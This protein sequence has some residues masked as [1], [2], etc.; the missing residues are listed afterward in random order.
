MP[1]RDLLGWLS[2]L[3]ES[4]ARHDIR[5]ALAGGLA[6]AVRAQ[7]RATIDIDLV[8]AADPSAVAAVR[9]AASAAG[10]LQTTKRAMA[11]RRVSILRMLAPPDATG[12]PIA[13]DCLLLPAPLE[14]DVLARAT[15]VSLGGTSLP[16]ISSA[17]TSSS[18]SSSA[19]APRTASTSPPSPV[20]P[21]S[22][23][24]ISRARPLPCAS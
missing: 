23:A 1:D 22:I 12:E 6:L 13:I 15:T 2:R 5:Y 16:V 20:P 24:P 14:R 19:T 18:S 17:R 11:F 9:T 4:F 7:P 10:L 3:A 8:V 21:R